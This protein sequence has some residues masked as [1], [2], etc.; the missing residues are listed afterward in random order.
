MPTKS[1]TR[2]IFTAKSQF[3]YGDLFFKPISMG[4]R[5][6]EEGD[7]VLKRLP[8]RFEPYA[9]HVRNYPG[10]VEQATAS[11]GEQRG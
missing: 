5:A 4:G 3:W 2:T 7:P 10:R 6:V 1:P 11:P 8:G 9:P